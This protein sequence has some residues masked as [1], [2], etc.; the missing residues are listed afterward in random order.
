MKKFFSVIAMPLMVGTHSFAQANFDFGINAGLQTTT[1]INVADQA[2]GP[3]LDFK[4]K[5]N[6]PL[7]VSAGYSIGKHAGVELDVI[8]ARQGQYYKGVVKP[9]NDA[10]IFLSQI[11]WMA[12][13]DNI[14]MAGT[15]TASVAFKTIKI[16]LLFRY[17]G[18]TEQRV[19]FNSFVGPQVDL[20]SSA[21]MSIDGQ[22]VSFKGLTIDPANAYRKVSIDGVLGVGAGCNIT[23]NIAVTANLRLE[24]GIT[25]IENKSASYSY[26]GGPEQ[27]YYAAGR[28]A[29]HSASG[30]L[31]V[32]VRYKFVKK[33]KPVYRKAVGKKPAMR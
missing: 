20:L 16:P 8:Y 22:V 29:T 30:G 26:M 33:E 17:T 5:I 32:A 11:K 27:Q 19:W 9:S 28:G 12:A 21:V 18:N 14:P 31:M 10:T 7:G 1:L 6:V 4:Q 25:D 24:Y 23:K 2:A 13:I 3:E 15:Y